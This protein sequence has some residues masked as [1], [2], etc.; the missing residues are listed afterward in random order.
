MGNTTAPTRPSLLRGKWAALAP[1]PPAW[2]VGRD[3]SENLMQH[4]Q[5]ARFRSAT[6]SKQ[7]V[8]VEGSETSRGISQSYPWWPRGAVGGRPQSQALYSGKRR[9]PHSPGVSPRAPPLRPAAGA[10]CHRLARAGPAG[11]VGKSA[12]GGAQLG[13]LWSKQRGTKWGVLRPF[14]PLVA[15]LRGARGPSG[16]RSWEDSGHPP[17]AGWWWWNSGLELRVS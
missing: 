2:S 14:I 5:G 12:R 6:R 7:A 8:L 10:H 17:G 3:Q 13:H 4:L 1:Q 9:R 16:R 15:C 11:P